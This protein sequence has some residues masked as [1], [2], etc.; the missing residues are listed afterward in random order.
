MR[1]ANIA[2]SRLAPKPTELG[3]L[4]L[5]VLLYAASWQFSYG[6]MQVLM[7]LSGSLVFT[8]LFLARYVRRLTR[9]RW[10]EA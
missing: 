1:L 5:G 4:L 9:D 8:F 6:L 7:A 3:A 10:D 2:K